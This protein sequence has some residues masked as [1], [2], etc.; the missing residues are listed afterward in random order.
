MCRRRVSG[1][2]PEG[3]MKL[4]LAQSPVARVRTGPPRRGH[5]TRLFAWFVLAGTGLFGCISYTSH[6]VQGR[7]TETRTENRPYCVAHLADNLHSVRHAQPLVGLFVGVSNYSE[8]SRLWSTPAHTISAALFR[9]PFYLTTGS[10]AQKGDLKLV[11]ELDLD[12]RTE[13]ARSIERTLR[14]VAGMSGAVNSYPDFKRSGKDENVRW[15]VVRDAEPTTR[16]NLLDKLVGAL[17]RAEDTAKQKG[18]VVFIFYISAHGWIGTDGRSYILPSDADYDV[19]ATWIDHQEVL[20]KVSAFLAHSRMDGLS[21][22]AVV[23]FDTCRNARGDLPERLA[24]GAPR[25]LSSAFVVESTSPGSYAWHWTLQSETREDI[26]VLS[27]SRWGFPLP[28]PKAK[29]GVIEQKLSANMSIAPIAS[30]CAISEFFE[31]LTAPA[32][33]TPSGV[34]DAKPASPQTGSKVIMN[35]S[36]WLLSSSRL[37]RTLTGSIPEVRETGKNQDMQVFAPSDLENIPLFEVAPR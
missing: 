19:P 2:G 28:P 27:E 20:A 22:K 4:A 7:T 25:A 11:T 24:V 3:R 9:E 13:V 36:D 33:A 6:E 18:S 14:S 5:V 26:E 8:P 12:P 21:R 30:N 29:R 31:L 15:S 10:D 34:G 17:D 1:H 23:V 32:G 16:K 37:L 35:A